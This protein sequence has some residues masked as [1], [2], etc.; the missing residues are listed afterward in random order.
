[1]DSASLSKSADM[2]AV[3]A[4]Y[5]R[6]FE[7]RGYWWW[8][9]QE[10]A[11]AL[12]SK[13]GTSE[14]L[15]KSFSGKLNNM[16][17]FQIRRT[18]KTE[19]CTSIYGKGSGI[20]CKSEARPPK[21]LEYLEALKEF[22]FGR[23]AK[24]IQV[25]TDDVNIHNEISGTPT[26]GHVFL[27]TEP[28]PKRIPD[29]EGKGGIYRGRAMKDAVDILTMS[30]GNPLIFTYSSGFGALALQIKQVRDNFCSD[31]VSLD[32]GKREWPPVGTLSEGGVRGV[33]KNTKLVSNIC[34][35]RDSLQSATTD[36]D[37]Y[38]SLYLKKSSKETGAP[39]FTFCNCNKSSEKN[40]EE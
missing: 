15:E 10:I 9:A 14:I 5:P 35:I 23:R 39:I 21:L 38:C 26:D 12:R 29:K 22:H 3:G 17:V 40:T 31:W 1:M 2:P 28:A 8:K 24:F 16:A 6:L 32:W 11:Y 37:Q 33:R 18:D 19:G 27:D 20:K 34:G 13:S 25:I 7:D 4:L 36:K 30:Y